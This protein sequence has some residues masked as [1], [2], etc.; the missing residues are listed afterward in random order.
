MPS[1][2]E[3][4]IQAIAKRFVAN[5]QRSTPPFY[6]D[7]EDTAKLARAYLALCTEFTRCERRLIA[8]NDDR[9]HWRE[10]ARSA[11]QALG[12]YGDAD[13]HGRTAYRSAP[14]CDEATDSG[15]SSA[16]GLG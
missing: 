6:P 9:A 15:H 1:S 13:T 8:T 14:Y 16:N 10:R 11:E 12:L 4:G 5:A 2:T 7:P 3:S